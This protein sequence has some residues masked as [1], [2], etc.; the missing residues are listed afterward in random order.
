MCEY[1]NTR[2]YPEAL[3]SAN[4]FWRFL[5]TSKP[6]QIKS[7][8]IKSNQIFFLVSEPLK[9]LGALLVLG[10]GSNAFASQEL[11]RSKNCLA[12]HTETRKVIGPSWQE[13]RSRY[14]SSDVE[15]IAQRVMRGSVNVWG[16]IP[17][18]QDRNLSQEDAVAAVATI[19]GVSANAA[20]NSTGGG[21]Q[22][23]QSV[24]SIPST[25]ERS[26]SG[27]DADAIAKRC[28]AEVTSRMT[29]VNSRM[30]NALQSNSDLFGAS[31][32]ALSV[33]ESLQQMYSASP[34]NQATDR[35]RKQRGLSSMAQMTRQNC[36][37][38]GGGP[39]CNE[40]P[41]RI[42]AAS[43]QG[44]QGGGASSS[45]SPSSGQ[46]GGSASGLHDPAGE[47]HHCV[48]INQ[49]TRSSEYVGYTNTCNFRISVIHC[50]AGSYTN[51]GDA[52]AF[53]CNRPGGLWSNRTTAG[54]FAPGHVERTSIPAGSQVY[55]VACREPYSIEGVEFIERGLVGK[56]VNRR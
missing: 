8:Q 53:A 24:P 7:N 21:S 15:A 34:C 12:C 27:L 29:P 44:M 42:A 48:Q 14:S 49:P 22:S 46:G 41:P 19:M 35:D 23:S 16:P 31:Q 54:R 17:K 55:F 51:S 28:D 32:N 20:A 2:P 10:F 43:P 37:I 13:I 4:F 39:R 52:W 56:C 40:P 18:P 3:K 33:I 1:C 9:I 47:A 50:L 30:R 38:G 45:S 11:L 6:N 25:S 5:M 26:S 36:V